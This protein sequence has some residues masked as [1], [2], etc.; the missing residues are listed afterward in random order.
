MSGSEKLVLDACCGGRM[1][2]CDKG[3]PRILA[4]DIRSETVTF[5]DRGTRRTLVVRPDVVGDFRRM[6]FPDGQFAQVMF[7]PPH[8]LHAGEG[9]WLF[10]KYGRLDAEMWQADLRAGFREC[11]R[12]LMCNGTLIF[13]WNTF[14]LSKE[15]VEACF[16]CRP[17]FMT[18]QGKTYIYTFL[19]GEDSE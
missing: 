1:M 9:S 11:M 16:P 4:Q 14:Q 19:K 6:K 17:T 12:V 8:L 15:K 10:K 18:R 2:W 3:D 5:T 7:D 13:K